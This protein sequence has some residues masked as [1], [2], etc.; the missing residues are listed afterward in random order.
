MRGKRFSYPVI[1]SLLVV[2]LILITGCGDANTAQNSSPGNSNQNNN[3]A[4]VDVG[5]TSA[6]IQTILAGLRDLPL[7]QFFEDSFIQ[8][9]LRYPQ[10]MVEYGIDES[11]GVPGD[12]LDD[13]SLEYQAET[14]QLEA[15]ILDIL[16]TYD[17]DPL[18]EDQQLSFQVYQWFLEDAIALDQY[19]EF[20]YMASFMILNSIH[21][22]T[23]Q[24]FTA[25]HPVT[26]V[27][28]AE[29]YIAR[30][31]NLDWQFGQLVERLETQ[32]E[33]GIV[34][35]AFTTDWAL[36]GL[37]SQTSSVAINH[38]YYRAFQE[39][40]RALDGLSTE[41]QTELFEKAKA[42]IEDSVIPA[43]Q[44]LVAEL[45]HQQTL[46]SEDDMGLWQFDGGEEYYN[47]LLRHYTTTNLTADEIYDLGMQE[48][49][50][51]HD[52]MRVL[53]DQL[54]YPEG[55]DLQ[56]LFDRVADDGGL[57][58]SSESV[59]TYEQIISETY[60]VLDQAFEITPQARVIVIGGPTGGY[61]SRGTLDGSRPGAFYAAISGSGEPYY[62]MRSLT[63][64]ETIP[65]H[66]FQ[67][68]LAREMDIPTFRR[69]I[70]VL[71]YIEGWALY[72]ERLASDMGWYADDPYSNLGRLQYEALRAARLVVDTGL[73]TK[74]WGF[75]QAVEF[76]MENVG[77]SQQDCEAQI[78]RYI[79]LPGQATAYM[80]GMLQILDLR[81]EAMDRLGEQFDLREFHS[82]ILDGGAIPLSMLEVKV[83]MYIED[84]LAE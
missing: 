54:G 38:P 60:E 2:C 23:Y 31:D 83:K 46:G 55:E 51:I 84:K 71:G 63:Y 39:K 61:Y 19:A 81:Q 18:T 76:F 65:G 3:S 21:N 25:T 53:F 27:Q 1:L 26:T 47:L 24:F 6:E 13:L 20:Q 43:Y 15:G 14:A 36:Y 48:L 52:E 10:S 67:I 40:V 42:A 50:R 74:E 75:E 29:N 64:H 56:R 34:P 16:L 58:R 82:V 45:E 78:A 80:V 11:L 68:E 72:A 70:S 33:M 62:Q 73:H 30:L 59:A 77:W 32:T 69:E 49:D 22:Q 7:D 66:H 44:A 41:D 12:A 4:V 79:V 8:L 17:I 28:Q 9:S 5:E 35:P 37:R 57:I